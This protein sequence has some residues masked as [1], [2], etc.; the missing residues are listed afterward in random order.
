[1]GPF[2][3]LSFALAK[4]RVKVSFIQTP[5]NIKRLPK[6]PSNLATLIN[7]VELP[8]PALDKDVLPDGAEASVD[9]PF[10][11]YQYLKTAYDMRKEIFKKFVADQSPDWIFV[12]VIP[13]WAAEVALEFQVPLFLMSAPEWVT[14][15]ST[16]AFKKHE[17]VVSF[18]AIYGANGTEKDAY[19]I[20]KALHS[21]QA[22]AVRSCNELEGDYLSS[23]E[24]MLGK[25]VIPVGLLPPEKP[26]GR[27]DITDEKW[28][29]IFEL[30]D[31][32]KPKSVVFVGFGSEC[33][34]SRDQTYELAYEI[35]LSQVQ[36]SWALRKPL[37]LKMISTLPPGFAQRT[38]GR[39][40]VTTG[41]APQ[42][43]ILGH[44]STGGTLFQCGW[45]SVV[46]TLQFGHT[47]VALP[48]VFD[49]ALNARLL[50]EKGL[51]V[52]IDRAEDGSCDKNDIAECLRLAM[53]SEEREGLRARARAAAKVLGDQE[54]YIAH[55]VEY[56]EN[57]VANNAIHG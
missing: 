7:L 11:K 47:L 9:I 21:C 3:Q 18:S 15:P 39:G 14:F 52:E 40:L 45:N 29:K 42:M 37:G 46:E 38:Q 1:M 13:Y 57:G 51:A 35:E 4:A 17:A 55:F 28:V 19:R 27:R 44:S 32:Q 56:V 48:F 53:V 8:L 41:W 34:L 23:L 49:Q 36:F 26:R 22:V 33:K 30:V 24:K 5:N 54:K 20:S 25:K 50:V 2:F 12:D 6:I 43:E 16:V 10:E 31:Q